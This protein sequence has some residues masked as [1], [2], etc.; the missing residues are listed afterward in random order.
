MLIT[1]LL[2]DKLSAEL[3]PDQINS[4]SLAH[5]LSLAVQI[6]LVDVIS[7][8]GVLPDGVVGHSGG[9][10]AAAYA[11]GALTAKEAITVAYYRGIACEN[12]PPGSM[13]AV[14]S[15]PEAKE[16]KDAL[17]RNGVQIACFNG[18]QNLTLAGPTEGIKNVAV[19]L[20]SHGIVSRAV[21]VTRA[22]HTRSMKAVV[23]EYVGRLRSVLH[24]KAGRVPMY[25][26]VTGLQLEGTEVG[27]DY[28]GANLIS[29]VLYTDAVTLA[30]TQADRKFG[31]CVEIGPHSLLSRPT[32]EIVK[33]LPDAP[34]LPYFSTMLRNADTEQQLMSLAGDLVLNNKR[35][36]LDRVNTASL[37]RSGKPARLPNH[38]QDNL[39]A[40]AWDYSSTPWT[41]PRNSSDWRFRKAPRHEILGTRCRG[42]NPS[43][44]TWRNKVSI[45]D[46]P[47][48]VDHQ[49]RIVGVYSDT[50]LTHDRSTALSPCPLPPVSQWSWK[51]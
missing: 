22:Y 17:E 8:W 34:Q 2:A 13:L 26:S 12:A 45:E 4:P 31:L 39:P 20:N 28:W 14:R 15:D 24:P 38:I 9:E 18:P 46:A 49:V 48:L 23:D 10:T 42:A 19:E 11:C 29:P 35:L 36:D 16:L 40:Y 27:A 33:S 7:S 3:T 32:S 6:A 43:A 44:P 30:M 25:S 5:P 37:F 1:N 50:I 51:L 41:E 47:W 21:A